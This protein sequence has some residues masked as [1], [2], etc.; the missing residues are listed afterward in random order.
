MRGNGTAS[1]RRAPGHHR[2]PSHRVNECRW[3][4]S[5]SVRQLTRRGTTMPGV[6]FDRVRAEITM[7]QVLGLLGFQPSTRSGTQWYGSCPLHESTSEAS[8][9]LVFCERGDRS[10]LLPSLPQPWQPARAVGGRHEAAPISRRGG[11]MPSPWPRRSVAPAMV[12]AS[13]VIVRLEN[14]YAAKRK[15]GQETTPPVL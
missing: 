9:S 6:D 2:V 11:P 10:L 5:L 12:R 3:T 1:F 13:L 15:P 8:S 14:P 7:E 4:S